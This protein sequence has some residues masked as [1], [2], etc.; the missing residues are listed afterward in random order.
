MD[1]MPPA[2]QDH[3]EIGFER[4]SPELRSLS[5][6]NRHIRRVCLPLLFAYLR[7][8]GPLRAKKLYAGHCLL[9]SPCPKLTRVLSLCGWYFH[10]PLDVDAVCLLLPFLERLSSVR[11]DLPDSECDY[12]KL[13][14][15]FYQHP[16][17]A[18][19]V[20]TRSSSSY[21][22]AQWTSL[23]VSKVI[24][25]SFHFTYNAISSTRHV[26]RRE[27]YITGAFKFKRITFYNDDF[28]LEDSLPLPQFNGLS[29]LTLYMGIRK[30]TFS[31]LP[32]FLSA[33]P[34]LHKLWFRAHVS[35]L[36]SLLS[37]EMPSIVHALVENFV[38]QYG[39]HFRVDCLGLS[40]AVSSQQWQVTGLTLVAGY[41]EPDA[42]LL[43]TLSLAS[44]AFP[45]I[46]LLVLEIESGEYQNRIHLD[47]FAVALARFPSLRVLHL[48]GLCKLLDD[49]EYWKILRG[50]DLNDPCRVGALCAK[51]N[52]S[53]CTSR[54][55]KEVPGLEAFYISEQY[56]RSDSV[57][58]WLYV[59]D[60][61]GK[62]EGVLKGYP[63][64]FPH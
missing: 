52:V 21:S 11:V 55:A 42:V 49:R 61:A 15:S 1:Y 14:Q 7:I 12:T 43:E 9:P 29:E 36:G 13:L 26:Y 63:D 38:V 64:R 22:I 27:N 54:I 47:D 60:A 57:R 37:F 8:D 45:A 40:R 16:T 56:Y 39:H 25:E 20:N 3:P 23:P 33:H 50:F 41:Y 30:T 19:V 17:L 2:F 48:K 31:W 4:P 28:P 59:A 10:N 5:L 35:G 46:E 58:G 34:Q 6:V 32:E 24:C 51:H 18:T 44:S 62:V 53:R